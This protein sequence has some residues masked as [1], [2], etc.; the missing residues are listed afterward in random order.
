MQF[1][2]LNRRDFITLLGG[3]GGL[4]VRGA[5]AA[6]DDEFLINLGRN[7]RANRK[8][9]PARLERLINTPERNS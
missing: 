2:Q 4:V 1:D 6:A 8:G 5:C 7:E 9:I 3:S